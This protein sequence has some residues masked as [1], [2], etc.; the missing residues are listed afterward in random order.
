MLRCRTYGHAWDEFY[1][2]NLGTPLWG[3]RLSLRCVRC[4]AERHDTV[5]V[6]GYIGQRRYIYPDDYSMGRDETPTRQEMRVS[7]FASVREKLKKASA[8]ND[9]VGEKAS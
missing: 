4:T 7:L 2:D 5:D 3:W 9:I 6:N 8:I 1:P